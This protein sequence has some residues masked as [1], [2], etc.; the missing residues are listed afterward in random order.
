MKAIRNMSVFVTFIC[1]AFCTALCSFGGGV[2]SSSEPLGNGNLDASVGLS[3]AKTYTHAYNIQGADVTVNGVFFTG[4]SNYTG[5][6]GS[7][8]IS[9][10]NK[11]VSGGSVIGA[12]S[13]LNTLLNT[14]NFDGSPQTLT[15]T[16]LVAGESYTLTFYNKAWGP[17]GTRIQQLASASGTAG[18]FDENTGGEPNANLLRYTFTATGITE[19]VAFTRV[20][21]GSFHFYGFS[22]EQI[23]NNAW[24]SG[25]DWSTA[26]WG[27]PGV[28]GS[29]GA[30]ADLPAQ[31][32]PASI[33]LDVP[34]TVGHIRMDG[35]SSW[36]I[37]GA[38]TLTLQSD[39]AGVSVLSTPDGSHTISNDITLASDVL[40]SGSG[41]LTLAGTVSGSGD[42]TVD[43]GTLAITSSNTLPAGISVEIA[44]NAVMQL[45]NVGTQRVA[46]LTFDGV[47]QHRGTWGA[48]GS[49]ARYTSPRFAGTG[50]LEVLGGPAMGSFSASGNLGGG[51]LDGSVG[52]DSG[53]TYFNAVNVDGVPLT[54][55]GVPFAGSAGANPAGVTYTTVNFGN[56]L[57]SVQSTVTGQMGLLLNDFNFSN[58]TG[59]QSLTLRN[60]VTGRTYTLTFYNRAWENFA[61][62][63]QLITTTSGAA[64][65]FNAD[66]GAINTLS[67]LTYTFIASGPTETIT[68]T[69]QSSGSFHLYGFSVTTEPP[70]SFT[71]VTR[72]DSGS[73]VIADNRISDVRIVEGT[74]T[75]GDI[76]IEKPAT[77]VNTLTQS[78]ADDLT[79]VDCTDKI[80]TLNSIVTES[81]AGALSITNG[82]IRGTDDNLLIEINSSNA[83]TIASV[84]AN[85]TAQSALNK[86]GPGTLT[87]NGNNV[88]S[89]STTVYDGTLRITGG[90]IGNGNLIVGNA[91]LQIDGGTVTDGG[92]GTSPRETYVNSTVNQTA[93]TMN[94]GFYF[95]SLNTVFNLTGGT[96]GCAGEAMMGFDGGTNVTVNISG[97]HVADWYVSRFSTGEV[98][99]NLYSGG[100]LRT[101]EM[102]NTGADGTI[103]FDG[104]TLAVSSRNPN[105]TPGDW[106]RAG[107]SV[108]IADGGAVIDTAAGSVTINR[109]LLQDG[110][111]TGG[112]TKT[113]N[114]TLTL[115]ALGT[116]A[117]D[118]LV[119]GG[120]LKVAPIPVSI[121]LVNSGFELPAYV[122]SQVNGVGWSYLTTDGLAGG[123]TFTKRDGPG[124]GGIAHNGSPWVAAN[125]APEG[126][127]AGF[128][129]RNANMTQSVNIPVAGLYKVTFKAANRPGRGA[130]DIALLFNGVTN[131]FWSAATIAGGAV[132][133]EYAAVI[134]EFE[135]GAY[136][137]DFA[138]A[139]PDGTD[140]ATAID[141]VQII[142]IAGSLPGSLPVSTHL[143]LE[144][145]AALDLN[146]AN[147]SLA[148]LS[149]SGDVINS[150][151][152]NVTI[153]VGS[154]N[155]DSAFAGAIDGNIALT[156]TGTGTFVVGGSNTYS[157]ATEVE[158]GVLQLPAIGTVV[159]VDNHS[160]ETHD[161][162]TRTPGEWDYNPTGATWVFAADRAGIATRG[163]PWVAAGAAIDGTYAGYIQRT[164][165]ISGEISVSKPGLYSIAFLAGKRPGYSGVQLFVD[166]DGVNQFS[167]ADTVFND[168]G[169]A[170]SGSAYLSE[171]SHALVFRGYSTVD[172]ATWIDR[173]QITSLGGSLPT[174]S[175]AVVSADAVLDLNGNSQTLAGVS[176]SGIVS[177]G[178]LSISGIIAPGG[179][180]VIG[181]LTL[182]LTPVLS[183]ATLLVDVAT[184][185][186]GDRL[187]VQ[188]DLDLSGMTL[189]VED[190]EQLGMGKD[191]T[192]AVCTGTLTGS[193]ESTNLSEPWHV[194][195]NSAAGT[196][197]I[198]TYK[199]TLI[200]LK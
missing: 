83:V 32:A 10:F 73:K 188:G 40:K 152:T 89:G 23:F 42:L 74:G 66:D 108:V 127:Q 170:F 165:S 151:S 3:T 162:L 186:A 139:S 166:I 147:Q 94:H 153:S 41:T 111:S 179:I 140:R 145:G 185:G 61:D 107:N 175:V 72:R 2:F 7:F 157:G 193:F 63:T 43:A 135:P 12:G 134:G 194:L 122:A 52:L 112:L 36:T 142:R 16:N 18:A 50:M 121:D 154:D 31:G 164:G 129:Q 117:G 67:L 87:L 195:I 62:R 184:D 92:G 21:T 200:L 114:N 163:A 118:T 14:F 47:L 183:E 169:G 124:N 86:S 17:A 19:S 190:L 128:L 149:G 48:A 176:G 131:G 155:S 137:L 91:T 5:V 141:D 115:T 93:G 85:G 68:F 59:P 143:T 29:A 174:G 44:T 191:Y 25:A 196:V 116:Y 88:Y 156:K 167:F 81:G 26:T 27:T 6:D 148:G 24:S 181:D 65:T 33:N 77:A 79:T 106:I 76:T 136:V 160:F 22:A 130:D 55:N 39:L 161:P 172:A 58:A 120:T 8:L 198:T 102:S 189:Q 49:G 178:T 57:S 199:G 132:F 100:T 80:L 69:R 78:A 11:T 75:P 53:L 133:K 97:S 99:V 109:P 35:P 168:A 90:R 96:S 103:R 177:N 159:P 28:P 101:D 171:G 144:A 38:N 30:N 71:D 123:W 113:G 138:G 182:A 125:A 95:K 150:S 110:A 45:S 13:G 34:V 56:Y 158:S 1:S 105:R 146:G 197:T 126:V 82:M 180:G 84:I 104:G 60:L 98:T 64:T 15:L 119:E 187:Y 9:G 20:D 51:D 46:T 192:V 70:N 37:A 54:I 173:I 4:V